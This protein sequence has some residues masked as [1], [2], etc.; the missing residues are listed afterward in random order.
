[1]FEKRILNFYSIIIGVLFIVSGLGKV[2]NTSGF[3]NL[4]GQYG[5]GYLMI[6]SPL[7]VLSE[8]L[9]G[10]FLVLLINPKFC[11][12]ISFGLLTI[13][14]ALFAF[15]HF[16]Y[17]VNNCGCFGT[18]YTTN[19]PPLFSF[20]RNFILIGMS[21][22]VWIK[23]PKKKLNA[24]IYLKIKI[25]NW[26]KYLVL[27][28]MSI[29]IFTAGFT[30]KAP[31]F[32]SNRSKISKFQNQNIKNTEL[33][34]YIKT[35][36]DSTYLIFCFSYTCPHCWNSIENLRQY[37]ITN[38]ANIMALGAL[39]TDEKNKDDFNNAFKP[40]FTIKNISIGEMSK[41]TD[42]YPTSFYI[43]H[44][45]IKAIMKAELPSPFVFKK[46]PYL[47]KN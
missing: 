33:A 47:S 3:S 6:L 18:L 22:I 35:S 24:P 45:T 40:N 20:I 10:L 44:D 31:Y 15:A 11:A 7:I 39:G 32:L 2:I 12:M 28:V 30:F 46:L 21:F 9:I 1:M 4:I 42:V 27:I 36:P 34:K 14:T 8:I 5:L 16:K 26:K 25:P 13:F 43:S 37:K 19:L 41:L 17:G 38:T 23:Y 29:S